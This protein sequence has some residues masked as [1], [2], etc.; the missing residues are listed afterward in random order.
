MGNGLSQQADR[1]GQQYCIDIEQYRTG[2]GHGRCNGKLRPFQHAQQ[3][4][5]HPDDDARAAGDFSNHRPYVHSVLARP[6]N[7]GSVRGFVA[8]MQLVHIYRRKHFNCE[9]AS[10]LSDEPNN[11]ID[12]SQVAVANP[13]YRMDLCV[14]LCF[15]LAAAVVLLLSVSMSVSGQT[16]VFLPGTSTPLPETCT[17]R[18][19]FGIDCPGCGLTRCFISIGHGEFARAWHFNPAGFIVYL[20]FAVQIPWQ[21]YQIHRLMKGWRSYERPWIYLLPTIAAIGLV[22]QWIVKI[23]GA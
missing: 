21:S 18:L 5:F 19:F 1:L 20:L 8:I 22:M 4:G 10:F 11:I 2:P 23:A 17:A 12:A 13:F 6:I 15:L 16:S 7:S 3:I 9:T 14:H